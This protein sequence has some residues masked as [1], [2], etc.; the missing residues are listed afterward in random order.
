[1]SRL[2]S[3]VCA[4]LRFFFYWGDGLFW[5]WE[6]LLSECYGISYLQDFTIHDFNNSEI[7]IRGDTHQDVTVLVLSAK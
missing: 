7:L 2:I 1:M 3:D 4:S 6:S 5:R